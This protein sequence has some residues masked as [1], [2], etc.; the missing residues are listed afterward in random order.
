MLTVTQPVKGELISCESPAVFCRS[1]WKQSRTR[2]Q[3]RETDTACLTAALL[4][5]DKGAGNGVHRKREAWRAEWRISKC[6]KQ[7]TAYKGLAA[8]GVAELLQ[9]CYFQKAMEWYS[10]NWKNKDPETGKPNSG[11]L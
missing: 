3:G 4:C 7:N 5:V 11:M 8:S 10:K 1:R 9:K 6:P 2:R